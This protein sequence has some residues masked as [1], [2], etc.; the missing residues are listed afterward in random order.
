MP[1]RR[2]MKT[3]NTCVVQF[4]STF[5]KADS[6]DG[7]FTTTTSTTIH[8]IRQ[9]PLRNIPRE[10]YL[11]ISFCFNFKCISTNSSS[12]K[13]QLFPNGSPNQKKMATINWNGEPNKKKRNDNFQLDF[14]KIATTDWRIVQLSDDGIKQTNKNPQQQKNK[15]KKKRGGATPVNELCGNVATSGDWLSVWQR[16]S[17][18]PRGSAAAPSGH[19]PQLGGRSDRYV[20]F[21]IPEIFISDILFIAFALCLVSGQHQLRLRNRAIIWCKYLDANRRMESLV[22]M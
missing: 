19:W 16:Q 7:L 11:Y 4:R 13:N 12:K 2:R 3:P 10:I 22:A 8:H 5:T 18:P 17:R 15:T 1:I 14:L 20:N 9:L 21:I 6:G